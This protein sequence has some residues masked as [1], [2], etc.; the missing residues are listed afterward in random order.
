MPQSPSPALL[1][2]IGGTNVR[3]A[4]FSGGR[5]EATEVYSVAQH[6][7]LSDV[8]EAVRARHARPLAA[9]FIAAAGPVSNGHVRL[10]NS[11]WTID[12]EKL[13]A[14]H[15][16]EAITLV[17]DFEAAAL[18]LPLVASGDLFPIAGGPPN[19]ALPQ[20][21]LGPGTGFGMACRM[22]SPDGDLIIASEGG[23]ASLPAETE[24]EADVI[25]FLRRRFGHVSIERAL[26]GGGLVN[27][28]RA[29]ATLDDL[30]VSERTAAEITQAALEQ[31]CAVSVA[32][33]DLFLSFL[34]G[35]AGNAALTFGA[36]GG[37]AIAGGITPRV[38]ARIA[39]SEL[40]T[41]YLSKGRYA[42]FVETIP[43]NVIVNTNTALLGLMRLAQRDQRRTG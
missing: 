40:R 31:R 14:A 38:I 17:N 9:A 8:I 12:T 29:V 22:P 24:R 18:G 23:H 10:T 32:A 26:S 13:R 42:E 43:L 30:S 1:A 35:V 28:Y 16:F 4:L 33:L 3:V 39:E 15:Q 36:R 25:S 27:L 6:G 21:I 5:L 7:S 37:V 20:V 2:D 11:G 41:R 19:P 34:G